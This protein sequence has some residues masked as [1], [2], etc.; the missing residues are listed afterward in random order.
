MTPNASLTGDMVVTDT[1]GQMERVAYPTHQLLEPT[2]QL[3]PCYYNMGLVSNRWEEC[4]RPCDSLWRNDD[5]YL[6]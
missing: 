3:V 2:P 1:F 6:R 4:A 5:C